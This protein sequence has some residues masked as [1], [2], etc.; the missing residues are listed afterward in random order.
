MPQG[1]LLCDVSMSKLGMG[2][3]VEVPA[4]DLVAHP[5]VRFGYVMPTDTGPRELGTIPRSP[6]A[7]T[8]S[9][10]FCWDPKLSGFFVG[11]LGRFYLFGRETEN[12][13]RSRLKAEQRA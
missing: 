6:W 11:F 12:R 5:F 2:Y 4:A 10:R 8:T 13:G 9:Q 3:R 1:K 7:I